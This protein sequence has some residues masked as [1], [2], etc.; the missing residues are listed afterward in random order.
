MNTFN[1]SDAP[2]AEIAT[3]VMTEFN[4]STEVTGLRIFDA[5]TAPKVGDRLDC[6]R[7]WDDG[8]PTEE[9]LSGTCAVEIDWNAKDLTA[10]ILSALKIAKSY[11]GDYVAIIGGPSSEYGVDSG[12]VI[13]HRAVVLAV[14]NLGR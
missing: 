12:E 4:V 1:F 11:C 9:T 13:I 14:W 7:V 10:E 3:V 6:S 8:E 2:V 5:E